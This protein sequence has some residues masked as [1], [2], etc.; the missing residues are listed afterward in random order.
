MQLIKNDRGKQEPTNL[1]WGAIGADEFVYEMTIRLLL[2]PNS[3]GAPGFRPDMPAEVATWK[4]PAE[5]SPHV[6][7]GQQITEDTGEAIGKFAATGGTMSA[8]AKPA[9]Q[10]APRSNRRDMFRELAEMIKGGLDHSDIL[11]AAGLPIDLASVDMTDEQL[12]AAIAAARRLQEGQ[13]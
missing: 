6:K 8:T 10:A 12:S 2:P 7:P 4:L 3:Q 11:S 13:Q 5:L 1:G 9:A